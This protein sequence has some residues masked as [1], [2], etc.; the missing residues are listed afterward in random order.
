[1]KDLTSGIRAIWSNLLKKT[2]FLHT[3]LTFS[4]SM[5]SLSPQVIFVAKLPIL[6]PNEFD[7]WK[8]RIKQYFLMT[9]YSLWEVILNGDS[10]VP[11]RVVEGVIQPVAPTTAEQRLAQKNELKARGTTSQNLAFV[12][13]S[14]TDSTTDY[15]SAAASVSA[16]C[17]K[18]PTSLPN[19]ESL[20]KVVI[21]TFF[22]NQ[23]TSP[24]L[25]NEARRFLQ[26][27]GK[28]LGANGP[29]L[30]C[31]KW[32]AITAIK[33]DIL[34]G[35]VG[36]P[37]IQEELVL[38]SH[39]E[40]LS[41]L[42][43]LL[44]ML[45]SL[46]LMVQE[47]MTRVIKKRRSLQTML[48][49]I[50]HPSLLLIMRFQPSGGY[51]A[52][53][54]SITGT[55][56]PPKPDL[57][58]NTAPTAVE[59]EHHAFN[60]QLSPTKPEQDLSHTT[61]P[62]TPIIED[63]VSDSEDESETKAPHFKPQKHMVPTAVLTQSKPVLNTAVRPVSVAVPQIMG[64]PQYAL[65]DK[66]VSDSGCSRHMTG[67]MSYLFDF[68]ELN[69]GYVAFRGNPKGGKIFGKGKIKTGKFEG[70]VDEGFLVGY[71]VN[72]KAFRV[73]NNRSRIIQETLHVNF[74][75]NRPKIAGSG[76]TWLFDIVILTRT[77]NY[78]PVNAGN[79][80]NLSVGFQDKFD[81]EKAREEV[82]QQYVLFPV[83]NTFSAVGPSNAAV[84]PTYGKFSFID[85]SQLSDDPDMLEL[86]DITYS[87]DENVVGAED[88]FNNLE[89][90]ITANLKGRL[91]K[92]FWLD[93]M[94]I[95]KPFRVFNSRSRIVQE[96]LHVNFL[97][98][99]PNIAGS[100][101]TWLFDIVSLTR[102]M[103]YK[104]V[105][106]GNQTNLS[107][108]AAF[109]E[110]EHDFD[111]KKPESEV[112]LSLS[113][114]A[115]SRKQD[116]KTKKEAKGK[117]PV[118]SVIGYRD[119]NAEFEDF[120]DNSSNEVNVAGSIV[121]TVSPTYGKSSFIDA[122]QLSD[123]PDMLELEDITY[124][125]D[126]NVIGAEA[127]FNNLETSVTVSPI[128]TTR[129]HKDHPV[130]QIIF[131]LSL[132]TQTKSMTR[133][134]K[135]QDVKSA[136]LYGTIKEE[137]YVCQ[138]LGF[139]DPYHHDKV[140]KVVKALYS[141]HQAPRAWYETLATYL[142]ENGFQ[143]GTIDQTL[144]IKKKKRDILLCMKQTVIATSSTEAEYVAAT[145]FEDP[146]HPDKVYKLVKALYG[147]HQAPR[148]RR[149]GVVIRDPEEELTT[150]SIIPANTKSKDKGKGI[151]VEEPKT[152]KKKQ[153]VEMDEEYARKLHAELNKDSD[154]DTAIEHNVAGFRLDYFKGMSYD[155]IRPIF[156][157]KFN[158][159]IEFLLKIKEQMEEEESRALQSINETL[160]QK[161]AKRRKLNKEVEDLKRHLEIVHDEDDDVYT[162]AT[163]LA[164]KFHVVD[165]EIINLNNKPYYKIIRADGTN[166][167][168]ISFLTLLKNL[169]REDLEAL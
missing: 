86:E 23:S 13:S 36:L 6:N 108:D 110:K 74:L 41:Q 82:D 148:A 95:A 121:L 15:V 66:G 143:R 124:S 79:Q 67:N 38:L 85:A 122:S 31:L 5:D 47:V 167:L 49:W 16:I 8:I 154:W 59:T 147:L 135:D 111:V 48:L 104:P 43:P 53:P 30:I 145:R 118:E 126:E 105:N 71:Y 57:V 2:T 144:F 40:G 141:L 134:V 64:N 117:S 39:K 88:E 152:L 87:D 58:F 131:D 4:V 91:M 151:M 54:P 52:V 157:A 46:R 103:N 130:S 100:G 12:S 129:I 75:E 116:D 162:E 168:Y 97:E 120:S 51:H 34:L 84:S 68:E 21:H 24:Q 114:N 33:R 169:E 11:T 62:I 161:E 156:E 72:S 89:T 37:R 142:L 98:N 109:D 69:G 137:V 149:K 28:N 123:D 119:L 9:G 139:E 73:F 56:M 3:R 19:V 113:S 146:D 63:R 25:D 18:L 45:W 1:S 27:T 94:L 60:V 101:P 80:T 44:L 50:F 83:T 20:S 106:A 136:F 112:I 92:D 125:D 107:A 138:P 155:D 140:Y 127:E 22:A 166:Q 153:Q 132:T 26:K 160:A 90:S 165:Y 115:Q 35:S 55:F 14:H 96:T 133:V 158:S 77:M 61:R 164:R 32:S 17:A 102:T 99:M 150:S 159:N 128:P 70:K 76:P 163:P 93:T 81:A 29:T 10:P 42:R 65:K 7:L 78:K